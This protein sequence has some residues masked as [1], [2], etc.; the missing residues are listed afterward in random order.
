MGERKN[1]VQRF[2]EKHPICIFCGGGALATTLEHCPPRALFQNKIAPE[3]FEF[4]SCAECNHYSSDEDLI[5]AVISRMGSPK[6][7]DTDGRLVG[8]MK[9]LNHQCPDFYRTLLP[10]VIE[11]R[12]NN[13]ELGFVPNH[14]MTHQGMG[15]LNINHETRV[16]L[17]VFS[18]KLAKGI[19]YLEEGIIFKNEDCLALNWFTNANFIKDGGYKVFEMLSHINGNTPRINRSN[20]V[21]NNQFEYKFSLS[22]DRNLILIQAKFGES[23]GLVIVGCRTSGYL[24]NLIATTFSDLEEDYKPFEIIQGVGISLS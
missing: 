22:D 24:E 23:F 18:K 10:S 8:M 4:S 7:G 13:R 21:L 2:L 17:T 14:G 11:A 1:K 3:G 16:A 9:A 5:V 20:K 19:S 6:F 12:R 15:V